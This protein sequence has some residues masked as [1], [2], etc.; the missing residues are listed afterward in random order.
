MQVDPADIHA[1]MM[2][3]LQFLQS[4]NSLILFAAGAVAMHIG[5]KYGAMDANPP[6]TT[7]KADAPKPAS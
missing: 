7:P 2:I 4:L 1:L 6:P 3:V 5:R